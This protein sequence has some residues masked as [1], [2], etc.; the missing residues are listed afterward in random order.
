MLRWSF[1]ALAAAV[2]GG[3]GDVSVVRLDVNFAPNAVEQ[4]VDLQTR[5]LLIIVQELPSN[6]AQACVDF[7]DGVP[8]Q[9]P[10]YEATTVAYPIEDAVEANNVGLEEFLDQELTFT[11]LAYGVP[12]EDVVPPETPALA[13]ACDQVLIDTDERIP[14]RVILEA[15]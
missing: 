14:V 12:P 1:G 6:P 15:I 8:L 4:G 11:V 5:S 3:C 7:E 9:G 13:G 2:L 10:G